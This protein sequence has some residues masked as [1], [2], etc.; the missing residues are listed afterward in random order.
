MKSKLLSVLSV[1]SFFT[2]NNPVSE[3][4]VSGH[5]RIWKSKNIHNYTIDQNRMCFCPHAGEVVRVT[6]KSDTIESTVR[7]SDSSAVTYPYYVTIDSLF[8]MIQAHEYDSI[9]VKYNEEFGYPESMDVDPQDHP[10]DGGVLYETNY[11]KVL[12]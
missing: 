5:L 12:P 3:V 11:L 10:V 7:L 2:C 6:V 1:L 4:D 8:G 9:A